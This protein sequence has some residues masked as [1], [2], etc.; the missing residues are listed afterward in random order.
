METEILLSIGAIALLLVFSA[1]FSGSETALT[2][3]S[4][5]RMHT[6]EQQ[7]DPRARLVNELFARKERLIGAVL[8]GNNLVNITASALA[9]SLMIGWAGDAG[10]AYA[11]LV[12]TLLVLI[13]A[14]VLPKTYAI[15]NP[16]GFALS[17]SRSMRVVVRLFGPVTLAVQAVVGVTLSLFGV[18]LTTTP[19]PG[20]SEE[21]LRGAIELHTGE[22][23]EERHAREMLR[24]I[25][26]LAE[27]EVEEIMIH[28][29]NMAM[30][31]VNQPPSKVVE[32]VL[33]SPYTRLPLWQDEPDNI[34]GVLHVKALLRAV[35]SQST[36]LDELDLVAIA[37]DPWFVPETTDLLS[38]LQAF[39]T[40]QEHFAIVVDEY[41]EVLGVV[42][43][44]DILE[45]IVGDIAD[46][47]DIPVTG[48]RVLTDG[49]VVVD[50][51]VTLRDLNRQ[52][53]WRLPD[54][55]ASTV[56]G[57]VLHEARRIPEV[58]QVFAFHGF[59]FEILRR[60]RNQITSIKVT[61]L[62]DA[63]RPPAD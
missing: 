62:S 56:A 26:D 30:I 38:Q 20:Q 12:M 13:F 61:A 7:G 19:A 18:R 46:E 50:G 3:A 22:S 55:E 41:G 49:S 10:I 11:T 45:E 2:A 24:S 6:L 5:S 35:H 1:F 9:T 36:N 43:L 4:R 44:E 63:A 57:L 52:F 34:V 51:T 39:R 37:N 54:E 53:E 16:D 15:H 32:E 58:G 60:Q 33:S 29:K 21:E 8:L 40:R 14:E 31:D 25:L 27:V 48:A 23:E 42:T 28:R 17:V 47:L 59:S